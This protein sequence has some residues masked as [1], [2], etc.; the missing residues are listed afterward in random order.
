MT[1]VISQGS[2]S[3][4]RVGCVELVWHSSAVHWWCLTTNPAALP[5]TTFPCTPLAH[6]GQPAQN[7][8]LSYTLHSAH[9]ITIYM[10]SSSNLFFQ[11]SLISSDPLSFSSR[12]YPPSSISIHFH[13]PFTIVI[14]CHP[15]SSTSSI[16]I[17]PRL[18]QN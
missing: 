1:W 8:K 18:C 10:I 16:P 15:F 2:S 14:H 5:R 9:Y 11:L 3:F 4:R 7:K 13:P 6:P 12:F 17:Y